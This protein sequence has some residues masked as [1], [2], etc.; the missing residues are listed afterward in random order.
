[1][2]I[3]LAYWITLLVLLLLGFW[4]NMPLTGNPRGLLSPLILFF[5]LCLIGYKIFGAPFHS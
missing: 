1:M 4:N 3:G 2:N 5:L